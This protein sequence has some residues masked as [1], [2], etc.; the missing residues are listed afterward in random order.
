MSLRNS[1]LIVGFDARFTGELASAGIKVSCQIATRKPSGKEEFAVVPHQAY[2]RYEWP[3]KTFFPVDAKLEKQV[4]EICYTQFIRCAERYANTRVRMN[5]WSDTELLFRRSIAMALELFARHKPDCLIF[6][7][8]PHRSATVVLYGV[9]K[10]LGIETAFCDQAQFPGRLWIIN[11]WDDHGIFA[12]SRRGEPVEIDISPPQVMPFYMRKIRGSGEK[13]LRAL[14][15]YAEFNL[16]FLLT[17]FD[18]AFRADNTGFNRV[19]DELRNAGQLLKYNANKQRTPFLSFENL[20]QRFVYFPL[21]LQPEMTTDITGGN[22]GNQIAALEA[23]RQMV[24]AEIPV[25]IKENPKQ[26]GL[27]RG[28]LFWERLAVLPN[29]VMTQDTASSLELIRR[30]MATAV[31]TGTAGWEALRSGKP[32]ILLGNTFWRRLP[33]AFHIDDGANWQKVT[34]FRFDPQSL[35]QGVAEMT[36]YSYEGITDFD[37]AEIVENFSAE[38]NRRKLANSLR[39]H[40]VAADARQKTA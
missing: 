16:R 23:V 8:I 9:A 40:F 10:A 32:V 6:A 21:H 28:P 34:A 15:K 39:E 30:A 4:R 20:P 5:D 33:G 37:Y 11:D 29:V 18:L 12:S 22:Y 19:L 2:V 14:A 17:P 35:A 27:M 25:I 38:E 26:N 1:A 3:Q 31:I 24:P 7:N 13:T 36:R